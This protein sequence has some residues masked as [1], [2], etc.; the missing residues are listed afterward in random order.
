MHHDQKA[1]IVYFVWSNLQYMQTS[2]ALSLAYMQLDFTEILS[3]D[4]LQEPEK[5]IQVSLKSPVK[6]VVIEAVHFILLLFVSFASARLVY[7]CLDCVFFLLR[8]TG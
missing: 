5:G 6:V 1:G 2:L 3:F 4:Q 8:I 7:L